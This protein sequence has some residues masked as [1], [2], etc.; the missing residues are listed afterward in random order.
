M[1]H[2]NDGTVFTDIE[3]RYG[4]PAGKGQTLFNLVNGSVGSF[5]G[6]FKVADATTITQSVG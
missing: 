5:D 4:V 6:T 2:L 3:L 1:G